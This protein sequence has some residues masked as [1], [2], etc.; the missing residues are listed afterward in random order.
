MQIEQNTILQFILSGIDGVVPK[1]TWAAQSVVMETLRRVCR[2]LESDYAL[3]EDRLAFVFSED[4]NVDMS[5]QE[6]C[7]LIQD[8]H[9]GKDLFSITSMVIVALEK[10]GLCGVGEAQDPTKEPLC[11][12]MLVASV[13]AE[14]TSD[15][16]YHNNLHFRKVLLHV[17]RM[18][19]VHNNKLFMDTTHQLDHTDIAKLIIA[20]CIHDIGH[21]GKGNIIDHKYH[22]AMIEKRSFLYAYPYLKAAGLDDAI[23]DD[24]KVMLMTTDVSP[25]GDPISPVNQLRDAYEHHF[26][27]GEDDLVSKDAGIMLSEELY[28]LTE[29]SHLCL[30][31]VMLQEADIMNSAGVDYDITRYE[32]IAISEEIGLSHS[33]P[34]DTL[35]FLET[36]CNRKLLSDAARFLADDNLGEITRRVVEDYRNGNNPYS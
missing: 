14:V 2:C 26:G 31:C 35:L 36:L 13:L 9:G 28:D 17:L 8:W 24:I 30:L 25:L 1:N 23:L 16:P 34:E 33:L 10:F 27:M 3:A 29:N 18:V 5:T 7:R 20:A 15:L 19:A 22:L 4:C 11:R 32:S 6:T 12:A 21:E